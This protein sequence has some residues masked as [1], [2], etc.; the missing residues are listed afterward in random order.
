[1]VDSKGFGHL[2][3]NRRRQLDMTQEQLA[4]RVGISVSYIGLLEVGRRHP[5]ESVVSRLANILGFGF[6]EL[7]FLANPR[8]KILVSEESNSAEPSAWAAFIA[9]EKLRKSL[10]ITEQEMDLL[11]IVALMGE[12][13]SPRDFIFILNTIRNALGR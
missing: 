6:S 9:D 13:R 7:F 12:V 2:I 4:R 5:S 10:N 3:R 1:M 11:S 8:T